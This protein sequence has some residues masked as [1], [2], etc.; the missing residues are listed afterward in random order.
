VFL[1]AVFF[2]KFC[3]KILFSL[4]CNKCSRKYDT[5]YKNVGYWYIV[6]GLVILGVQICVNVIFGVGRSVGRTIHVRI[7]VGVR[8]GV[9]SLHDTL[10]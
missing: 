10:H 4:L 1:V 7:G 5:E 9:G 2:D 8:V 3:I 6:V